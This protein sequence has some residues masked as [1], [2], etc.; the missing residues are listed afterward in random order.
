MYILG[1]V[2]NFGSFLFLNCKSTAKNG[3][4]LWNKNT[5]KVGGSFQ[6]TSS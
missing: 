2:F 6:G 3:K 4:M 1:E 5:L